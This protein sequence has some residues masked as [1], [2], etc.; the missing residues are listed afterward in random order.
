MSDLTLLS[1]KEAAALLGRPY[2]FVYRLTKAGQLPV[3]KFGD[4]R[5]FFVRQADL[6]KLIAASTHKEAA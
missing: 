5:R 1:I 4:T 3:V 2:L 6:E